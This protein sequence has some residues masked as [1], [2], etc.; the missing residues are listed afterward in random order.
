[1]RPILYNLFKEIELLY[2]KTKGNHE[3]YEDVSIRLLRGYYLLSY[4][5]S[6]PRRVKA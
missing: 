6:A 4:P 2:R 5:Y 1:M 3:L